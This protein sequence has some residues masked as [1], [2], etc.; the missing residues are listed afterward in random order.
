MVVQLADFQKNMNKYLCALNSGEI[1]IMENG[2]IIACLTAPAAKEI[3][4][5]KFNMLEN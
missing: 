3:N 1:Y 5:S 4:L 2:K